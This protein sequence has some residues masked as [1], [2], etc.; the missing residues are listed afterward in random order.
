MEP[1]ILKTPRIYKG[2]GIYK[3]GAEG[4]GG[5][6]GENVE[7]DGKVYPVVTIGSQKWISYNLDYVPAG[8]NVGGSGE[9][10]TPNAWYYN[11]NETLYGWNNK[12]YGLLYNF[13]A[14][15][16][17]NSS[18]TD[19]W[20]VPSKNDYETLISYLGGNDQGIKIRSPYDWTTG[21]GE[22]LFKFSLLPGGLRWGHDSWQYIGIQA[23]LSTTTTAAY[24]RFQILQLSFY[25]FTWQEISRSSAF[26]IRLVKDA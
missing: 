23:S 7:I 14:G 12:K 15:E 16:V 24:N 18:L 11:N 10:S 9:I 13:A 2:A 26:S 3:N 1:T 8:V 5:G 4:G 20:R 22:D 6:G 21:L 17:V 25:T 19:G